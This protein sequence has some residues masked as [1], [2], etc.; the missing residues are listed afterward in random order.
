MCIPLFLSPFLSLSPP[1]PSFFV[2]ISRSLA[3][4]LSLCVCVCVCVCVLLG[5]GQGFMLGLG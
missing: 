2:A 1:H 3:L 4:S 5:V